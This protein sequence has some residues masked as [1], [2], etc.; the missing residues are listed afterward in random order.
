ME[1]QAIETEPG[2]EQQ[3]KPRRRRTYR[4]RVHFKQLP[5]P[6]IAVRGLWNSA[7][8]EEKQLAHQRCVTMLEL[9]LGRVK[10]E[11][12]MERLSVP[13]LRLWQMSQSALSGMLAG[14]LKQPR[15]RGE[16]GAEMDPQSD[17]KKDA[18]RVLA[19]EKEIEILRSLV[20]LLRGLPVNRD[21]K[22]DPE[23]LAVLEGDR[24]AGKKRR[25]AARAPGGAA[26]GGRVADPAGKAATRPALED[27]RAPGHDDEDAAR[28]EK[29][30]T[31]GRA[32]RDAASGGPSRA[33]S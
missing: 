31:Q 1:M 28:V 25:R 14:L 2:Q 33:Q 22:I 20:T 12:A 5:K 4:K 19:L 27:R 6:A 8:E 17:P 16:R 9:W 32:G 18:K 21:V 26:C 10:K 3:A 13:A 24:R 29:T 23:S 15:T 7:S 11:E 30:R